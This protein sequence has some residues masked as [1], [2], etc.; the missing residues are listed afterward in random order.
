MEATAAFLHLVLCDASTHDGGDNTRL[1]PGEFLL[2]LFL[3]FLLDF[4]LRG[5]PALLLFLLLL[6]LDFLLLLEQVGEKGRSEVA[7][8]LLLV[9]G[10][11]QALV[12]GR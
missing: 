11:P 8:V 3:P 7:L 12:L 9:V 5:V 10:E 4:L 6:F 2:G 1:R